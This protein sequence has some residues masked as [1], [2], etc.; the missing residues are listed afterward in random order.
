MMCIFM[1]W[2]HHCGVINKEHV[3]MKFWSLHFFDTLRHEQNGHYFAD[4]ILECIFSSEKYATVIQIS[5]K[6]VT[7]ISASIPGNSF[8]PN[9]NPLLEPVVTWI[10]DAIW[11]H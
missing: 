3:N 11:C 1:S 4:N 7:N 10:P 2:P 9:S 8:A 5:L 6:F